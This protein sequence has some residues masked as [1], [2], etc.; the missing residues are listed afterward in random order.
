MADDVSLLHGCVN[1]LGAI[2][3]AARPEN[4]Q[5]PVAAAETIRSVRQRI[6]AGFTPRGWPRH[7]TLAMT[8][9][10]T[11]EEPDGWSTINTRRIDAVAF[12][13]IRSCLASSSSVTAG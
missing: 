4:M 11:T 1:R 12:S 2:A 10:R 6:A 5:T 13:D 8:D 3:Q 9:Q 7:A